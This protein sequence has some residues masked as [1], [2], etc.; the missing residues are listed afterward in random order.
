[1]KKSKYSVLGQRSTAFNYIIKIQIRHQ[2]NKEWEQNACGKE[3]N[4]HHWR[5]TT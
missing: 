5:R 4:V 2:E 1:M 3:A